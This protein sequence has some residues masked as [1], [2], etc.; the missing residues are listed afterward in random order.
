MG[1]L[2]CEKEIIDGGMGRYAAQ[3]FLEVSTGTE[4]IVAATNFYTNVLINIT[5][6]LAQ[7]FLDGT[8]KLTDEQHTAVMSRVDAQCYNA[9]HLIAWGL[10]VN[11][12]A[13]TLG[14]WITQIF[15]WVKEDQTFYTDLVKA[16]DKK[17]E[18]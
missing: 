17:D 9:D 5:Q 18:V 14:G 16:L 4:T 10:I 13:A 3:F 7:K 2:P 8:Y 6:P 1:C 15:A 12:D 11:P